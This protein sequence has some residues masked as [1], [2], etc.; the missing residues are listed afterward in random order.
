MTKSLDFIIDH[1]DFKKQFESIVTTAVD[2]ESA[3]IADG[4]IDELCTSYEESHPE[5]GI[6]NLSHG[7][8]ASYER[9]RKYDGQGGWQFLDTLRLTKAFWVTFLT[10]EFGRPIN[11]VSR[12]YLANDVAAN[13][14]IVV[15][16]AVPSSN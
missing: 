4:L 9:D 5:L 15:K 13:V 16:N 7:M 3:K 14:E 8:I 11:L 12:R 2:R 1:L 6:S 10:P